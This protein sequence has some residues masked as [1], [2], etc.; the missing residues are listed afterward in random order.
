[1][2]SAQWALNAALA[3]NPIVWIVVAI[4]AL[5]ALIVLAIVYWDEWTT[6][7]M[8]WITQFEFVRN[9]LQ[10]FEDAWSRIQKGFENGG[11]VGALKEIGKSLLS[12]LLA[13]IEYALK[14]LGSIPGIGLGLGLG[15]KLSDLRATIEGETPALNPKEAE[16]A[17]LKETIENNNNT[18]ATLTVLA[19]K[20]ST[21]L[22][23]DDNF[24][25]KITTS[26]LSA[27]N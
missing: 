27:F 6:A 7:V 10:W 13:P 17:A 9:I 16:Q 19:P 5:I 21:Q 18:N 4:A 25:P 20:G 24:F 26:L 8:K 2:T 1:M 22:E 14:L 11:I 12:Y 23:Q 15:D 3:V